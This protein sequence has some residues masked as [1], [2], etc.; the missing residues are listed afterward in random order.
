MA[1]QTTAFRGSWGQAG[2]VDRSSSVLILIAPV[3][4]FRSFLTHILAGVAIPLL[5]K[6]ATSYR[7]ATRRQVGSPRVVNVGKIRYNSGSKRGRDLA[8]FVTKNG[9]CCRRLVGWF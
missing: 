1:S 8:A 2:S 5:V 4:H 6:C 3:S 7:H 9:V